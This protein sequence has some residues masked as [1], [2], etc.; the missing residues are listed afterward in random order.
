MSVPNF[1][2]KRPVIIYSYDEFYDWAGPK[3]SYTAGYNLHDFAA[4]FTRWGYIVFIPLERFR[5]VN[6]IRGSIDYLLENTE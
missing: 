6:A 5:K 1:P 3:L 4:E 2:G